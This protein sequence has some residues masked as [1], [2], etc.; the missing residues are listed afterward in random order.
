VGILVDVYEKF[1]LLLVWGYN[2]KGHGELPMRPDVIETFTDCYYGHWIDL[3][4]LPADFTMTLSKHG[5]AVISGCNASA[6]KTL[7]I[8][9]PCR[10]IAEVT[11]ILTGPNGDSAEISEP[12]QLPT[13]AYIVNDAIEWL[14]E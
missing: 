7:H 13:E 9:I 3:G 4:D 8:R 1:H 14:N 10:N 6:G 5:T 12:A 2:H 11:R